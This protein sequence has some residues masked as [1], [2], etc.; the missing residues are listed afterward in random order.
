MA[1]TG[2]QDGVA[3]GAGLHVGGNLRETGFP[4]AARAVKTVRHPIVNPIPEHV[5]RRQLV[6]FGVELR[7]VIDEATRHRLAGLHVGI[8][9]QHPQGYAPPL[10][11]SGSH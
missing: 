3:L 5:D 9:D 2:V 4:G 7:I 11:C 6:A 1:A 8:Q 10:S